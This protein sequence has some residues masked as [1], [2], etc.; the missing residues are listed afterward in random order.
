VPGLWLA[1]I[2]T[3]TLTP[4]SV[5][6]SGQEYPSVSPDG[7]SIAFVA[8]GP[9]HD[10]VEIPLDPEQPVRYLLATSLGEYSGAWMRD[11]DRFVYVTDRSGEQEL[12]VRTRDRGSDLRVVAQ[13][14]LTAGTDV[15]IGA[16]DVSPDG[17]R[18]AYHSISSRG[19]AAIWISPIGGG[20]P[21][22]L[23]EEP[24]LQVAPSWSADGQRIALWRVGEGLSVVQVGRGTPPTVLAPGATTTPMAVWSPTDEWIAYVEGTLRL[25][26]PDGERRR[27]LASRA[28]HGLAWSRDG[29]TI[30]TVDGRN[31]IA[32]DVASG[33][34]RTLRTLDAQLRLGTPTDPGQ[35]FTVSPDGRSLLVTT[36]RTLT[37]IWI[38]KGFR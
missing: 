5:G 19:A 30:Y 31:L 11:G 20:T 1:D 8:G 23:F 9:D 22:R 28:N 24:V 29:T 15:G 18:V 27:D 32:V 16:P 37:D 12:R 13:H 38:L 21:T 33:R 6:L 36:V 7:T 34:A 3:E 2:E 25:V 4:I 35:R 10:L 26:S 17:R 14:D